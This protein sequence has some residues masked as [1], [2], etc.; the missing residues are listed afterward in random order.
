MERSSSIKAE[1]AKGTS[2]RRDL[3]TS[4]KPFRR[5]RTVGGS[6]AGGAHRGKGAVTGRGG[7]LDSRDEKQ[8]GLERGVGV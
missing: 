5:D 2:G 1:R 7:G 4:S 6:E 8:R 3:P